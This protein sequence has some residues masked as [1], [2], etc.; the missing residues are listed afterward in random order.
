MTAEAGGSE[1][2]P[3]EFKG[4][5][6]GETLALRNVRAARRSFV[7]EGDDGVNV[8]GAAGRDVAG[9]ERYGYE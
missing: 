5:R 9:Q 3:H 7:A 4:N 1:T 6:A 8:E 2:R